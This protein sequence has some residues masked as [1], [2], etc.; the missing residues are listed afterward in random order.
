M[1]GASTGT[2]KDGANTTQICTYAT[3]VKQTAA[4]IQAQGLKPSQLPSRQT[5]VPQKGGSWKAVEGTQGGVTQEFQPTHVDQEGRLHHGSKVLGAFKSVECRIHKGPRSLLS[6]IDDCSFAHSWKGDTRQFV[7]FMCTRERK[8][9]RQK[10]EHK[11]FIWD[12][13]PYLN[14][15]GTL[16]KN[17]YA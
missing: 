14:E 17:P 11:K 4:K 6:G 12:L 2:H 10:K 3:V 13:G 1:T 8:C 9:C 15:N 16:W 7:C 5:L